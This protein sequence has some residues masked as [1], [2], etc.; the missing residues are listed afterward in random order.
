MNQKTLKKSV[1]CSGIGLHSGRPVTMRIHP[2][3][4]DSGIVFRR[5]DLPD[6]KAVSALHTNLISAQ[7][8]TSLGNG[9][10]VIKTVEHLLSCLMGLEIDNALIELDSEEVP[11]F[12]GSANYYVQLL[13]SAGIRIQEARRKFIKVYRPIELYDKDRAISIKPYPRLRITYTIDFPHPLLKNQTKTIDISSESFI[14][15]IAPARTFCLY[16]EIE[17]LR[18]Q[19]LAK[20]GSL[21]NAIVIGRDGVYNG[22]LRFEDECVRH[23]IL[24][25]LGDLALLGTRILG[26]ITVYKGG[27]LLHSKL[28]REILLQQN[29]WYYTSGNGKGSLDERKIV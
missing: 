20:G 17:N 27:H 23:K 24:D 29:S 9:E 1:E 4:I 18:Q 11:V 3:P 6:R 19:G 16:E 12:D 5:T 13:Q 10:V 25:L 22:S 2:A 15:E 8:A 7:Y 21:E 14:T 26:H 28:V